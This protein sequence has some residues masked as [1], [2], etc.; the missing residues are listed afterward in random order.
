M[1]G[2]LLYSMSPPSPI[3]G[4]PTLPETKSLPGE[5][6]FCVMTTCIGKGQSRVQSSCIIPPF[7]CQSLL[8]P[9]QHLVLTGAWLHMNST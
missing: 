8:V 1:V 3:L 4:R 9:Q 2:G 6:T 5:L 7:R